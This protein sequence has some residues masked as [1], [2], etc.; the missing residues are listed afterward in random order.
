MTKEKIAEDV[1][2]L[3][4]KTP[5]L[6]L[7]KIN[8]NSDVELVGKLESSNPLSSVKD[9]ISVG[10]VNHAEKKGL[11]NEDTVLIEPTSG[12]TGIGLAFVAAS[13]GYRLILTMPETM[14]AERK[15]LLAIFGAEIVL[16]PG[17]KGMGGAIAKAD[18]L[19][20]STENSFSVSQFSNPVNVKTHYETTAQ[21]IWND[22]DGNVDILVSGVGTGGT[23]S[24]VGE[25]LK[26]KNPN[27]KVIAV[28][29]SASPVLSGEK[30]GPHKIQGIGAGVIPDIYDKDIVDEIIQVDD[31]DAAKTM[32][33]LAKKEG[34]LV[35]ISSGA[36][37]FAGLQLAKKE[38]NKGKR[39]LII[40]P[41]T[42][43]RYLSMEWVF[44][45]I[46]KQYPDVF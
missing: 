29:P 23:V 20:K 38:E 16:T 27:V 33:E 9:R 14:S 12:N 17:T 18:E 10:M 19:L 6:K 4:G 31:N 43:E 30:P 22:T 39:I 46:Y 8:K 28:E 21:E 40:L 34:V 7:N 32:I 35:G 45:D 5:L 3:V 26:E 37:T 41:D 42:G 1:T 15:K 25:F 13:R 11:I 44:E 2:E 24:G 36:A